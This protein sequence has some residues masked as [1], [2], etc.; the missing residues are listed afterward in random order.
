M[1][2]TIL[3]RRVVP[4]EAQTA[5][6]GW[7]VT[8]CF[9]MAASPAAVPCMEQAVVAESPQVCRQLAQREGG[10]EC[11][12]AQAVA[13]ESAGTADPM[14][15]P[16]PS[17]PT[18]APEDISVN[19]LPP[20]EDSK[21]GETTPNVGEEIGT[22]PS[23]CQS[24]ANDPTSIR[25]AQSMRGV[26]TKRANNPN[27]DILRTISS[28]RVP[29]MTAASFVVERRASLQQSLLGQ[30]QLGT[31]AG[32]I[33]PTLENMWGVL[34][35]LRFYHIVGNAGIARAWG[36]VAV[37]F[38]CAF[39]TAL[40]IS[41]IVT[42]GR[43][44]GG[45]A[46]TIIS[47]S[48]GPEIGG[49]VGVAYWFGMSM[50]AVLESIGAVEVF[51]SMFPSWDGAG[52]KQLFGSV[53]VASLATLVFVGIRVVSKLSN[54]FALVVVFALFSIYAGVA[55]APGVAESAVFVATNGTAVTGASWDTFNSNWGPSYQAGESFTTML[56]VFF[57]SFT[58]I[59]SGANRG[60]VLATPHRSIPWG[61]LAAI[62][63][64]LAMY[65][66]MM[67]L[68]GSVAPAGYLSGSLCDGTIPLAG[69][70]PSSSGC[71]VIQDIGWP[72]S[73]LLEWGIIVASLSQTLQN[74]IVAPRVLQAIA[75][76]GVVPV[77]NIFATKSG[78]EPRRALLLT[79]VCLLEPHGC[80]CLSL[81]GF[82][83]VGCSYVVAA[84]AVL[85]GQLE[86][87][88]PIL[89]MCFLTCYL[90][91]NAACAVLAL[92]R[93]PSW[94]PRWR[95]FHWSTSLLGALL[96]LVTM[97]L[98]KV[99]DDECVVGASRSVVSCCRL[100]YV[101]CAHA[102]AWCSQWYWALIT[103]G[104]VSA[105]YLYIDVKEVQA[106][107]GSGLSGLKLQQA[108]RAL[109][110]VTQSDAVEF[111]VNWRPQI[112]CLYSYQDPKMAHS[113]PKAHF[114]LDSP[115]ATPGMV[116]LTRPA[117]TAEDMVSFAHQLRKTRGMCLVTT[118]IQG[119][120][121]DATTR[122]A[123]QEERAVASCMAS[124][125]VEG[126]PK[127]VVSTSRAEGVRT[128]LQSAGMGALSPNTVVVGW[129]TLLAGP[130]D[131][132]PQWQAQVGRAGEFV[133]TVQACGVASKALLVCKGLAQF[134]HRSPQKGYIDVWWIVHD[135]DLLLL[136]AHLLQKHKVWRG[137]QLRIYM[138]AEP[139]EDVSTLKKGLEELIADVRIEAQSFVVQVTHGSIA[140]CVHTVEH[141]CCLAWSS[142]S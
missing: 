134:P 112:I 113:K 100:F 65:T 22:H 76:D 16:P 88:A 140:P 110:A 38:A 66:S 33:V 39:M 8:P 51:L 28:R 58:G 111:C 41:A 67:A 63:I 125:G 54:V 104:L 60:E 98:I 55:A 7:F 117:A 142:N 118:V 68:W 87:V 4:R 86:L 18:M 94:R 6:H 56:A 21:E 42:N 130:G 141:I 105:L 70:E 35:F 43:A 36:V 93:A 3:K 83:S 78:G 48:L 19:V 92:M 85:M 73:R 116:P 69:V 82:L 95:F 115:G 27:P 45:G 109:L 79:Y 1:Y 77:L 50:S 96:C 101:C 37:S 138:V 71:P 17:T 75:A 47:R 97:F 59:L 46:Y 14:A 20:S 107:W 126:F 106:D 74:F 61:T 2:V 64:S 11:E 13:D 133:S 90:T 132:L 137:C 114:D 34:I 29:I 62:F 32:V 72:H 57:P 49:A 136:I 25:H 9:A 26:L 91:L 121:T 127:A 10:G 12:D 99:R 123:A 124:Y 40:S 52:S 119:E 89:S 44:Q 128:L 129:P 30:Q 53:L 81:T 135:G 102:A 24:H 131:T 15:E 23:K 31:V 139:D 108:W 122:A 103:L 84:A 5:L 120:F 80:R